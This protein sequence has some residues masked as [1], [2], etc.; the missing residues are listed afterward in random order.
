V[1]ILYYP[2]GPT[3]ISVFTNENKGD[4]INLEETIGLIAEN[5]VK[6]WH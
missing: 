6:Q 5:L 4:F 1:G 3:V 2:G